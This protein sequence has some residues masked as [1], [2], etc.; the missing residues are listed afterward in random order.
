MPRTDSSYQSVLFF[1][2]SILSYKEENRYHYTNFTFDSSTN[3]YICPE[4]KTLKS[5]KT[6][7]NKTKSRE[8]NHNVYKG[9]DCSNCSN[10]YWVE[11]E[12]NIKYGTKACIGIINTNE[13]AFF[14]RNNNRYNQIQSPQKEQLIKFGQILGLNNFSKNFIIIAENIL[15][16]PV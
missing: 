12:E 15:G 8:W 2:D 10:V 4:G 1:N 7:K 16:Q 9:T 13:L 14:M 3:S 5:W 6:R 11:F